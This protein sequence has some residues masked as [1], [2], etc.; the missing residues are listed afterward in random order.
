VTQFGIIRKA[1]LYAGHGPATISK[2]IALW[3]EKGLP[4]IG[5]TRAVKP[6]VATQHRL[7]E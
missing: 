6:F 4:E 2:F 7:F 1:A 5:K 3:S